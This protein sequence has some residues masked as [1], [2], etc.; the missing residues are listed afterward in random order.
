MAA[1]LRRLG[2]GGT[3]QG[4]EEARGVGFIE[5]EWERQG[6]F[7]VAAVF[8]ALGWCSWAPRE[9]A[10]AR[11]QRVVEAV[12]RVVEIEPR[13]R[14][15]WRGASGCGQGGGG[16]ALQRRQRLCLLNKKPRSGRDHHGGRV[17]IQG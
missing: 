12:D 1:G 5:T 8:S 4:R 15:D 14:E 11:M 2:G 7:E 10:T 16:E 9:R 13:A 3:K 6:R 17:W